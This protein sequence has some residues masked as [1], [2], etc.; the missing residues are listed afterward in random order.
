MKR[1]ISASRR[2]DIPAYHTEWFLRRLKE[3]FVYVRHPFKH[4]LERVSL[5]AEDIHAIVFWSKNYSPLLSRLEEVERVTKALFFHHTITA[6]PP[7][8]EPHSPPEDEATGDLLYLS[9]RYSAGCVVWRFD[10][11]VLTDELTPEYYI[12]GFTRLCERLARGVRDCY[13]SFV[14]LYPKV[15][16]RLETM[17]LKVRNPLPEEKLL[18]VRTLATTGRRYGIRVS[19]CCDPHVAG[20]S[21]GRARCVDGVKLKGLFGIE[22]S[23]RTVPTRRG[24]RCTESVDVGSYDTCPAGCI[25]CYANADERRVAIRLKRHSTYFN[26]LGFNVAGQSSSVG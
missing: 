11:I 7:L 21:A 22:P 5:R 2:T 26:A 1:V 23:L 15:S 9:R 3:G 16:E 14:N 24:C 20:T 12:E 19:V 25:Y 8:F 4:T 13:V 10:P 18:L 6:L 17:G